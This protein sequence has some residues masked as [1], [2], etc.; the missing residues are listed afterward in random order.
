MTLWRSYLASHEATVVMKQRLFR[1]TLNRMRKQLKRIV[2]KQ[3]N[4]RDPILLTPR[5]GGYGWSDYEE[6]S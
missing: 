4:E 3:K 2:R 5:I 6:D 1:V